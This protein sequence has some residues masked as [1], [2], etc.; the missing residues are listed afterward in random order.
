[1]C[2]FIRDIINALRLRCLKALTPHFAA[3][4]RGIAMEFKAQQQN[5]E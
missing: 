5:E 1:M 4:Q 2:A 3:K